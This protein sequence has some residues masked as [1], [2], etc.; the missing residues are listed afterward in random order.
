[1]AIVLDSP[2]LEQR[3]SLCKGPEVEKD[4]VASRSLVLG[5]KGGDGARCPGLRGVFDFT[6]MGKLLK[7]FQKRSILGNFTF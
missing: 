5:C 1:M 6:A 3:E 7:D 4:L 2:A